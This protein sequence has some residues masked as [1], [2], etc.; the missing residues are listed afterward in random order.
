MKPL[1][2]FPIGLE[3]VGT[4]VSVLWCFVSGIA[5]L[6]GLSRRNSSRRLST[7]SKDGTP[8][9]NVTSPRSVGR[10]QRR[11]WIE[12]VI[13]EYDSLLDLQARGFIWQKS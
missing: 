6:G 8:G 3:S 2:D 5:V 4:D 1:Q 7:R 11:F 10:Q 9:H 12:N 13:V